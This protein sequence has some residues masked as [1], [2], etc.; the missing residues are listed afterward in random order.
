MVAWGSGGGGGP[1][2]PD[3]M[4]ENLYTPFISTK[5]IGHSGLGLSIVSKAVTD[6]GGT[7]SCTSEQGQ[8]TSFEIFLAHRQE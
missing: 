6:L 4:K 3:L 5:G 2:L 8:G 1:G 7:I